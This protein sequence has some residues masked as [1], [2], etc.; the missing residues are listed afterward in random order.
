[1]SSRSPSKR[2][3]TRWMTPS[4]LILMKKGKGGKRER[5]RRERRGK[6]RE[7]EEGFESVS[8][9]SLSVVFVFLDLFDLDFQNGKEK[10]SNSLSTLTSAP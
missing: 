3:L 6:K 4:V 10:I 5:E 8:F 1:M 7:E 9:F 2:S